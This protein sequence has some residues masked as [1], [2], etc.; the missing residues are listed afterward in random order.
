MFF[1]QQIVVKADAD[2]KAL[3]EA[4]ADPK[5]EP[6]KNKAGPPV[7]YPPG[8]ELFHETMH[9]SIR[10][11]WR[12]Y[13]LFVSKMTQLKEKGQHKTPRKVHLL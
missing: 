11:I 13:Y 6:T 12:L 2:A 10:Y 4:N 1:N 9:V 8:H 7:Y 3:A 5:K